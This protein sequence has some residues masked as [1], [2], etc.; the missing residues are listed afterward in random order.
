MRG[1][2]ITVSL[3]GENADIAVLTLNGYV[4]S[5]TLEGINQTVRERMSLGTRRFLLDLSGITYVSRRGWEAFME[6]ARAAREAGGGLAVASMSRDVRGT[7]ELM[8][9]SSDLPVFDQVHEAARYLVSS[10]GGAARPP[11]A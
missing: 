8:G 1:L 2:E 11:E 4:D 10:G 9:G 6:N 7:Y 3:D 5:S